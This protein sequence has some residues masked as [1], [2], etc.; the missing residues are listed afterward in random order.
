MRDL[1][2]RRGVYVRKGRGEFIAD[3]LMEVVKKD[4]PWPTSK[5]ESV[6]YFQIAFDINQ[7]RTHEAGLMKS[8]RKPTYNNK[9]LT[10]VTKQY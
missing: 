1:L 7:V 9:D 4:T 2:R 8:A 6:D 10:V 3:A 5:L